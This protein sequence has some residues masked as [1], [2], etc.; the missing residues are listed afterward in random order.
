MAMKLTPAQIRTGTT[1]MQRVFQNVI[2]KNGTQLVYPFELDA[3]GGKGKSFATKAYDHFRNIQGRGHKASYASMSSIK[4]GL[5]G[6]R[7]ALIKIANTKG[8]KDGRLN[9]T[10]AE[11]GK[12]SASA[13][14][15]AR[16]IHATK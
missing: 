4:S 10:A 16:W 11:L 6:L 14:A 9:G 7:N 3:F 15:L 8:N 13:A 12:A 2:D 1:R 5:R